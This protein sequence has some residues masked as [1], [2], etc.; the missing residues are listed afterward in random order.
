ML[1]M[2]K[3]NL[4]RRW[5]RAVLSSLGVALG[6]TTVVAL[7]A[8][9]GGLSRSAV[10]LA[11]PPAKVDTSRGFRHRPAGHRDHARV[12]SV[13]AADEVQQRALPQARGAGDGQE[14]GCRDR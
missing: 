9:A 2:I 8:V 13:Q 5:G 7:L 10:D 3:V 1:E 6:V 11:R 14:L 12:G 4:L